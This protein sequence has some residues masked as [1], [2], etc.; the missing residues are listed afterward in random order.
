MN[1][2]KI[3]WQWRDRSLLGFVIYARLT[4]EERQGLS[5]SLAAIREYVNVPGFHVDKVDAEL[6]SDPILSNTDA[7]AAIAST[8]GISQLP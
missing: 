2:Y 5:L 4:E 6:V 7:R 8:L 3:H 1:T